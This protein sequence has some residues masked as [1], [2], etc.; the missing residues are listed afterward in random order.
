[1]KW[2]R[3]AKKKPC[4]HQYK[5]TDYSSFIDSSLDTVESYMV[6]CMDCGRTKRLD[7][8]NY[9]RMLELKLLEA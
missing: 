6:T 9:E 1:M 4:F 5:L 8:H 2:F 7:K 3:K